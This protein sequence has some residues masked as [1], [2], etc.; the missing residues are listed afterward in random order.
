[1]SAGPFRYSWGMDSQRIA[2]RVSDL[3]PTAVNEVLAEVRRLQAEGH[4]PVSLMRGQPDSP[5]SAA[6][7]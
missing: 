6:I 2:P 1:M 3:R 5:T 4:A 7:S